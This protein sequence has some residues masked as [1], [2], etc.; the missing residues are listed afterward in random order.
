MIEFLRLQTNAKGVKD[1]LEVL[2]PDI[3]RIYESAFCRIQE[4]K[5]SRTQL[6]NKVL[7]WILYV[8]RPLHLSELAE[9]LIVEPGQKNLNAENRHSN[10]EQQVR[11]ICGPF[12]S[13][14]NGVIHIAHT[15]LIIFAKDIHVE[16]A[17]GVLRLTY[18]TEFSQGY[19]GQHPEGFPLHAKNEITRGCISYL[20]LN[21]F[22]GKGSVVAPI[23]DQNEM[24]ARFPFFNYAVHCWLNHVFDLA[25]MTKNPMK[26]YRTELGFPTD[27]LQLVARYLRLPHSWTYLQGLVASSSVREARETLGNNMWPIRELLPVLQ[28]S[29]AAASAQGLE[30]KETH[31]SELLQRW[32]E[33]A[34]RE[35]A[36]IQDLSIEEALTY[37][38]SQRKGGKTLV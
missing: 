35:L 30:V 2:S 25:D 21:S 11:T 26:R 16:K 15:S 18:K 17:D 20:S 37:I 28:R 7:M 4:F 34:L 23:R 13:I 12:V 22:S 31:D 5:D 32:I 36:V 38:D 27:C 24:T 14:S 10:L 33:A 19:G 8:F 6:G 1:A 9:A 3:E 29:E